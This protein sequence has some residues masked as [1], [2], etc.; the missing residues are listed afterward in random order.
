MPRKSFL[1]IALFGWKCD[2]FTPC[3]WGP[4]LGIELRWPKEVCGEVSL[5]Q[6]KCC[7]TCLKF[8]IKKSADCSLWICSS[9]WMTLHDAWL[10]YYTSSVL[11]LYQAGFN[12]RLINTIW[13]V[14]HKIAIQFDDHTNIFNQVCWFNL[15][16]KGC[17]ASPLP[18]GLWFRCIWGASKIW[19]YQFFW[20][21]PLLQ[22]FW[23]CWSMVILCWNLA[24]ADLASS[25]GLLPH[26][27]PA[28]SC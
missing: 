14:S 15:Q 18:M 26:T 3:S 4:M 9:L 8:G 19:S 2:G 27:T 23:I 16:N 25:N 28:R 6:K 24:M 5:G 7:L 1:G 22:L 21:E 12:V 11:K 20:G 13:M 17:H 10:V